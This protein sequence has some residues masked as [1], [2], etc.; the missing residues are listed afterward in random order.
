M[1]YLGT[2]RARYK[3]KVTDNNEIRDV[4]LDAISR[5]IGQD[6]KAMG[7]ADRQAIV[8]E[9]LLRVQNEIKPSA[10]VVDVEKVQDELDTAHMRL[11]REQAS[12]LLAAPGMRRL[13]RLRDTAVIALLLCTGIR[14]GELVALEVQDLRQMFQGEIALH[15][16]NGK[17]NK[18]R[19]IPYGELSWCLAIVDKWLAAAGITEGPVVRG[20]EPGGKKLRSEP[21][22]TRAINKLMRRYPI[23]IE[24]EIVYVAPHDCRRT[25]A[26]AQ[27]LAGMDMLAI[28]DN[29]GHVSVETTQRYIGVL[30]VDMRRARS[31]YDFDLTSLDSVKTQGKL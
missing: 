21:I 14:E 31:V 13:L 23:A 25:Y 27:F 6:V 26:K 4:L 8:N 11:T 29:L 9:Q 18:T 2:I 7:P 12:A 10:S 15:V 1:S 28:R 17:G 22:T 3:V 5:A 24:G 16:R 30:D 19:L 20:F